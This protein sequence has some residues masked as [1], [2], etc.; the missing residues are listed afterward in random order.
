L[1]NLKLHLIQIIV[2]IIEA[3]AASRTMK[4]WVNQSSFLDTSEKILEIFLNF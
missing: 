3:S 4:N 1:K 2:T